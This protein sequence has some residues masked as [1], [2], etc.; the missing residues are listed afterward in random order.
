MYNCFVIQP[1]R[2]LVLGKSLNADESAV[3]KRKYSSYLFC[4][5]ADKVSVYENLVSPLRK[6]DISTGFNFEECDINKCG[7][8]IYDIICDL[9]K[10]SDH[11]IFFITSSYLEEISFDDN[12]LKTVLSCIQRDIVPANRVLFIIADNCELPD[13]LCYLFPEASSN[14][15]DWVVITDLKARSKRISEWIK[16]EKVNKTAEVAVPIIFV[17]EDVRRQH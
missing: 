6:E 1:L 17:G 10:Q 8:S 7:R 3:R 5:D 11:L 13:S 12:H 4:A 9:I 16:K 14:I 2:R 15:Q